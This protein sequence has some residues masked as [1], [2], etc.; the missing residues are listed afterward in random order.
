MLPDVS[1]S[2]AVGGTSRQNH[3]CDSK[4]WQLF[5]LPCPVRSFASLLGAVV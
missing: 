5:P 3:D 4:D 2:E 1:F